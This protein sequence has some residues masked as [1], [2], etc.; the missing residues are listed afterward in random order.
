MRD[1]TDRMARKMAK[2]LRVRGEG[3]EEVAGRAGRLLPR[4][5]RGHVD[6]LVEAAACE[7]HPK[8]RARID[9]RAVAKAERA[10]NQFLD[11]QNPALA[12]WHGFLDWLAA[13]AFVVVTVVIALFFYLL[14][15]GYFD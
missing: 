14:N 5:L 4:R 10:L 3:L 8:H 15:K 6:T 7:A 9:A 11:S 2:Q 1:K 12:R 13:I